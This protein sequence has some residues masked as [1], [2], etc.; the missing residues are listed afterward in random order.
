VELSP[1]GDTLFKRDIPATT[2]LQR[3]GWNM[4]VRRPPGSRTLYSRG[5]ARDGSQ[6]YWAIPDVGRGEAQLIVKFD[7]LALR[8]TFSSIGP[9]RAYLNLEKHQSDVWVAMLK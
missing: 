5:V 1:E 8:V 9:D 3:W 7:D 4:L 6:G 2:Q